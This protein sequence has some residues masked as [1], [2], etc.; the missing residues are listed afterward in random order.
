MNEW[1]IKKGP[2]VLREMVNSWALHPSGDDQR[3]RF[4]LFKHDGRRNCFS[5]TSISPGMAA[6]KALLGTATSVT[7]LGAR[8]HLPTRCTNTTLKVPVLKSLDRIGQR[9]SCRVALDHLCQEM[10]EA[11]EE[12]P[13]SQ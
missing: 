7:G 12:S 11:C 4:V 6:H 9:W 8:V 5:S 2:V 10:Q 1:K 3:M 13:L